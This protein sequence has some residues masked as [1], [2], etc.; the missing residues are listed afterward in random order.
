MASQIINPIWPI[1]AYLF[2][3]ITTIHLEFP[4]L[5]KIHLELIVLAATLGCTI[6]YFF[7]NQ[8]DK[9]DYYNSIILPAVLGL[10]FISSALISSFLNHDQLLILKND[11]FIDLIKII[12]FSSCLYF[13]L[14]ENNLRNKILNS[15]LVFYFIFGVYFLYRYLILQEVRSFD[16]RPALKIR[17]GD[18]NF[19]CTFFSMTIPIAM[20]K[21]W[22]KK[23]QRKSTKL[24]LIVATATIFIC[25]ILTESRMGIISLLIGLIYLFLSPVFSYSR[26]KTL[27][28]L[29]FIGSAILTLNGERLISRFNNINDKSNNDRY[30]TWV[31]GIKVFID[32]PTTGVGMNNAK[33]YF[34][35]NTNFPNFQSET[36]QL[37]VHNTFLKVASELGILG[38][39]IFIILF[40]W[41]WIKCLNLKSSK[42]YFLIS[43]MIILTL[44]IMT[45]GLAYKD[46]F[47]IQIYMIAALAND[48]KINLAN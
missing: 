38:L 36:N 33:N 30:L 3:S 5:L 14:Q 48:K 28:F 34:Y 31:N 1:V 29:F 45:I 41:P 23:N 46:L 32:N 20:M 22:E 39:T 10:L 24:F 2:L 35:K 21:Y 26:I 13:F 43:S 6:L 17:H 19:L 18:A 16:L 37:E 9:S 11:E 15:S 42:K 4:L 40:S 8:I 7:I 47:M 27:I 12:F 25:S 44:S